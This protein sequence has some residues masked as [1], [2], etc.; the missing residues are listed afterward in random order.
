MLPQYFKN[1][2]GTQWVN[3]YV[4]DRLAPIASTL[5]PDQKKKIKEMCQKEGEVFGA[6]NNTPERSIEDVEVY[7]T[8]YEQ[9]LDVS[10]K[11]RVEPQ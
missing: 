9:V 4:L 3:R 7:K 1:E 5:T 11:K 2:F 6:I 10:Q 8:D